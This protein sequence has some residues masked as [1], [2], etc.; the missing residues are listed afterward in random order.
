M[1]DYNR[2]ERGSLGAGKRLRAWTLG[3]G[4]QVILGKVLRLL[5]RGPSVSPALHPELGPHQACA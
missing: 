4:L 3:A 5:I 2:Q 1:A